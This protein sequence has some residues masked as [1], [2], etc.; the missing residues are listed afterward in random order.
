MAVRGIGLKATNLY[1]G[2]QS[3]RQRRAQAARTTSCENR[4]GAQGGARLA[5]LPLIQWSFWPLRPHA[6]RECWP[7]ARAGLPSD[8]GR[9]ART[10]EQQG[11]GCQDGT[12][13]PLARARLKMRAGAAGSQVPPA[14]KAPWAVTAVPGTRT[15]PAQPGAGHQSRRG[16]ARGC[17]RVARKSG[18]AGRLLHDW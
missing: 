12:R 18:R 7:A 4:R 5:L 13:Q 2:R 8:P 9:L 1:R 14:A 15:V 3:Q 10:W 6:E 16:R 17:P 11:C